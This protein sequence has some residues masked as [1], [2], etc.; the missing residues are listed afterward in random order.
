MCVWLRR[1]G[2][3]SFEGLL[4]IMLGACVEIW[5]SLFLREPVLLVILEEA[6]VL[7]G[8]RLS[9]LKQYDHMVVGRWLVCRHFLAAHGG[10]WYVLFGILR[11]LNSSVDVAFERVE[12]AC[13]SATTGL[14]SS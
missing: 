13:C 8:I 3:V 10:T 7:A 6:S 4:I 9:T 11:A 2:V 14:H 1:S 12:R 5:V